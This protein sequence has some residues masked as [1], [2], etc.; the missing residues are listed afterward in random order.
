MNFD[1]AIVG[2]GPSG[3]CFAQSL[4]DSGLR[5][6]VIERQFEDALA[7]PAFDGREIALTHHSAKLM[8]A[9]G[10]WQRIDPSAISPLRDARVLNGSSLYAMKIDHR[11][12]QQ[13]ELG[14]LISNCLIRKAAFEAVKASPNI[15]LLT[16]AEI[17][18]VSTDNKGAHLTLANGG[19]VEAQL[20]VAADSRFSETRRAMGIAASQHDFGKTMMVCVMAH[21][22]SHQHVAWEWFDYGQTLALLPMNGMRSSVV[23][24]LPAHDI[25]GLMAMTE[26]A[27]NHAVEVRFKH[28]L[29]AM[30]LVSTR[31]AYP[32]VTVYADR[33]VAPR[34]ALI[35][36]AAVGM[37]P[38]TAHGFNF[39]LRGAESLAHEIKVAY[40]CGRNIA[41]TDL[42]ARYEKT[43]K[44]A[45]RPL[46]FATHAIAKLYSNDALP[47]RLIRRVSLHIGNRISPFKRAVAHMLTEVN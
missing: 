16:N 30:R 44:R 4:A 43:H 47:A 2:A 11:D 9:L 8:Q 20:I 19:V 26:E 6:A 31:H 5:I 17:S 39:G 22:V 3:L 27:F 42:L 38:V 37:H 41:S 40:T 46:F 15:T 13:N 32:L 45:T 7:N 18:Q 33:F 28:R 24:T 29:G 36:D 35:G 14:Y 25:Q 12:S 1:I 10:L 34:F 21:E 23:I